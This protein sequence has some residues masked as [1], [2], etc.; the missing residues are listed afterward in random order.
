MV[1]VSIV[2][3]SEGENCVH[4]RS[5]TSIPTHRMEATMDKR[6]RPS[7]GFYTYLHNLSTIDMDTHTSTTSSTAKLTLSCEAE[8]E[9]PDGVFLVERI[10]HHR[11]AK[12]NLMYT[13]SKK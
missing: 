6:K 5:Q 7:K 2:I 12:V 11:L 3:T 10:I 9:L 1:K 4:V 8:D 13:L